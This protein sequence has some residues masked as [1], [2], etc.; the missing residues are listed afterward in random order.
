MILYPQLP[1]V[2]AEHLAQQ[3]RALLLP[4]LERLAAA[5][6]SSVVFTPTGGARASA[7]DLSKLRTQLVHAAERVGYPNNSEDAAREFDQQ[8]A[9]I[10]HSSM[11]LEPAEAAKTGMWEFLTCVLLCDLVRW[12]FPGTADGTPIERF[13][14]G[15]RNTFQRLWWRAYVLHDTSNE[16]SYL[17]IRGLG[18]DELVQIMER[19][20]LAGSRALSRAVASEL[21]RAA[22]RHNHLSRRVLIRDVQK[23]LRRLAVFVSFEALDDREVTG[24]VAALFDQ[25]AHAAAS[26]QRYVH[27]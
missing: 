21:I 20:W 26:D 2:V 15:R 18:E 23:R 24:L 4:M 5:D 9:A 17:L 12:R 19:P 16:D 22:D 27:V 8:A 3:R 25:V 11:D 7:S 10:L 1:H 13:L 6:E 14:A